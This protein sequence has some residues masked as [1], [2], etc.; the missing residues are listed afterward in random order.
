[1]HPLSLQILEAEKGANLPLQIEEYTVLETETAPAEWPDFLSHLPPATAPTLVEISMEGLVH[2]KTLRAFQGQLSK[3]D[4]NRKT[5]SVR[6]ERYTV[7]VDKVADKKFEL[8]KKQS[9]GYEPAS[10]R[11]TEPVIRYLAK[12]LDDKNDAIEETKEPEPVV[13]P[14]KTF[15]GLEEDEASVSNKKVNVWD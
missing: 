15:F 4:K 7:K 3:R 10:E 12:E 2:D 9:F 1:M 13:N 8:L 14:E 11:R 5:K 6:E